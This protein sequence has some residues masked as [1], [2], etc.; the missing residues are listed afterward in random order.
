MFIFCFA[1]FIAAI[2][3]ILLGVGLGIVTVLFY[4]SVRVISGFIIWMVRAGLK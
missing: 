4:I 3:G 2:A 1:F